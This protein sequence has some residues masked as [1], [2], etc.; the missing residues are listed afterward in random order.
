[1]GF[2]NDAGRPGERRSVV[3]L[4]KHQPSWPKI[5]LVL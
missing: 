4:E 3:F 5:R 2:L 1:M